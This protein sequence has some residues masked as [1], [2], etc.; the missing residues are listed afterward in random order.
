MNAHLENARLQARIAE[1]DKRL[2]DVAADGQCK[3]CITLEEENWCLRSQRHEDLDEVE[4]RLAACQ[5]AERSLRSEVQELLAKLSETNAS[6][7][8][9]EDAL[10][11]ENRL[12][13]TQLDSHS[14]AQEVATLRQLL[15]TAERRALQAEDRCAAAEAQHQETSV[16]LARWRARLTEGARRVECLAQ[17]API[18]EMLDPQ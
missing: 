17:R 15:A 14:G 18:I 11:Q 8:K 13:R 2:Q 5:A 10:T 1:L 4:G 12:L 16:E 3:W 7:R 9:R 6:H